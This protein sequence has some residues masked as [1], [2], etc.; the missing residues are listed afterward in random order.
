MK[1]TKIAALLAG[2]C[3]S[4]QLWAAPQYDINQGYA[5]G[6]VV[7][8]ND[9]IYKA[10]WWAN[11]GDVP[12]AAVENEWETAWALSD[13]D[14]GEPGEPV[15]PVDPVEPENPDAVYI[16][17]AEL[18]AKEASLT[19]FPEMEMVKATI[20]TR[21]NAVVEAVAPGK[22]DNPSNVQRIER[23]FDEQQFEYVFPMRA[24]EYTY[25]GFL[26]AAAKFPAF[27]GDYEDGRNAEEICSKTLAVAVAHFAQETGGHDIHSPI[28]EWRQALVHVRE[29]GWSEDTANGYAGECNPNTWQGQTWPCGT[30]ANG[31]FK[32]YFGRGAK[33]LSYNYNYGP[34]SQAMFGTVRTLLDEPAL[35]AD[36]WLNLASAVFFF[37]Y[38]QPPKPSMLHVIDGTWQPNAHDIA[39]G[40]V[41]G[42]GVTT[43]IMNGGVECGGANEHAQSANRIK[44]Y[45]DTAAYFG[46]EISNDEVLGCK[47]MKYFDEYGAGAL[48]I[49]W[50]EDY[51]YVADNPNGGKS[52]A[53]QLVGYQTAHSALLPGD[54]KKCLLQKFPEVV[55]TDGGDINLPPVAV[56]TGP[57][58]V[59]NMP[60]VTLSAAQ[61][62]DPENKPLTYAWTLPQG[63]S[64]DTVEN[65]TLVA[66]LPAV[67]KDTTLQFKLTVT[68]EEGLSATASHDL[69]IIAET[70]GNK[71]P[72][73]VITGPAE[74]EGGS[75]LLLSGAE[76]SDAEGSE[77]TFAWTL[78]A[79]VSADSTTEQQLV[80]QLPAPAKDTPFHFALQVTD[81]KGAA[82]KVVQHQV[83]VKG[84]PTAIP[85]YQAGFAYQAG[86]QVSNDGSV[87]ECKPWPAT[88]W[89]AGAAW[90]YEP[91]KGTAWDTAWTKK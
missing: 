90:A 78:P 31:E 36:S 14:G 17:Q 53:C 86:D 85:A 79:G 61:S 43:Q 66:A 29:M 75:E 45:R 27:C 74:I 84:D 70:D 46:V 6:S 48:K 81:A 13:D 32:S 34:F 63:V 35:V 7:S 3:M 83:V 89:C 69:T 41:P 44:Y 52:Y 71:A 77:L 58:S 24:P 4:G 65:V 67:T 16:S 11:A 72:V 28:P 1:L 2:I 51:S 25:R 20:A 10:K 18:D 26:Q 42:F 21:D 47:G 56:I 91:G 87:Y 12:G 5:G 88:G 22:A 64:A 82:S 40:L 60:T 54:Y 68:D 55:I 62:T 50:E 19:S 80:V 38:P 76:S 39:N 59:E 30:L 15:D 33:Q 9:V 73:A 37:V 57:T 8:F 49:S 23:L